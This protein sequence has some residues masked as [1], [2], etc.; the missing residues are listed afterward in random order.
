MFPKSGNHSL[1]S[2]S[3]M[4]PK[5]CRLYEV[6]PNPPIDQHNKH[7][8]ITIRDVGVH[9]RTE[10]YD[11]QDSNGYRKAWIP[12]LTFMPVSL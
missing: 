2:G 3:A 5:S 11:E 7:T 8:F 1:D 4:V 9:G 6:S 12:W 10:A